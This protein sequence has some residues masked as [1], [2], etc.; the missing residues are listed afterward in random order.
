MR[1]VFKLM[2][3]FLINKQVC[4][5]TA[6]DSRGNDDNNPFRETRD[7]LTRIICSGYHF[8]FSFISIEAVKIDWIY[9]LLIEIMVWWFRW[10]FFMPFVE[11]V[12][13]IVL[14]F[15]NHFCHF[16]QKYEKWFWLNHRWFSTQPL[17]ETGGN[18]NFC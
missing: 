17:E 6:V 5:T 4:A 13:L 14:L 2:E 3:P 16:K 18:M 8:V 15:K 1:V 10:W 9:L 11:M 12:D 7:I